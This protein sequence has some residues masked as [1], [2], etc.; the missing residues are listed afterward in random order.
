MLIHLQIVLFA[1]FGSLFS[2][3]SLNV[4]TSALG[5]PTYYASLSLVAVPG[6]PGYDH[7]VTI[8]GAANGV[9]FAGGFFGALFSGWVADRFGRLNGFRIASA[10]GIVGGA[11][12]TGSVNQGMV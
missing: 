1:A 2:G 6:A 3:Y 4:I 10:V 9:L 5:Q 8:I 7:T 11:L 12:Q